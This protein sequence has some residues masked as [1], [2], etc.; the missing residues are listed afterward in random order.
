MKLSFVVDTL[1]LDMN[2]KVT[3]S[4]LNE[5]ALFEIFHEESTQEILEMLDLDCV[6]I[7]TVLS[8]EIQKRVEAWKLKKNRFS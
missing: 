7:R 8:I 3:F 2:V 5:Q 4:T 6:T 1:H